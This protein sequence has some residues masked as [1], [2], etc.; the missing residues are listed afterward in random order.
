[1][2][3]IEER[4]KATNFLES[5]FASVS[6]KILRWPACKATW[7]SGSGTHFIS[8]NISTYSHV[9]I[10]LHGPSVNFYRLFTSVCDGEVKYL[11]LLNEFHLNRMSSHPSLPEMVKYHPIPT[12]IGMF[13]I[14]CYFLLFRREV[15]KTWREWLG[16]VPHLPLVMV[17]HLL[18]THRPFL[19]KKDNFGLQ[20]T[21]FS[22]TELFRCEGAT[23]RA[24]GQDVPICWC[25]PQ[26]V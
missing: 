7:V 16:P 24:W 21:K 5:Y 2:L 18:E 23:N 1:M 8:E 3:V 13:V 15:E 22:K 17:E 11:E 19:R 9:R 25:W 4:K 6:S 10:N 26:S 12:V 20:K 14:S